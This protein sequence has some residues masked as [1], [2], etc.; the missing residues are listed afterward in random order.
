MTNKSKSKILSNL[1]GK[2][3]IILVRSNARAVNDEI[4]DA[5]CWRFLGEHLILYVLYI[6][7]LC[8]VLFKHVLVCL[9]NVMKDC[10]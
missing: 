9:V 3:G 5:G 1:Y 6:I 7:F 10:I 2:L 8:M 4:P